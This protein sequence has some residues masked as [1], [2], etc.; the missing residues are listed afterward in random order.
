MMLAMN[1]W[2]ATDVAAASLLEGITDEESILDYSES[3][4]TP[5]TRSN[6]LSYGTTKITKLASNK[7]SVLGITQAYHTCDTL[8]LTVT[9]ERKVNGSYSTYKI[10]DF[11][12]NNV[13]TLGKS[14]EVIVPRGYYYRVRGYHAA[15]D[16]GVRES[17]TTTTQGVLID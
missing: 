6:H 14:I 8:Y 7:V 16:S 10:F 2:C 4:S 12:E 5:L 11:T 17:T 13:Y 3:T 1:C 15:K 9:L